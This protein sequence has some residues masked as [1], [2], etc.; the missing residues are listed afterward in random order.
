MKNVGSWCIKYCN[1]AKDGYSKTA[2]TDAVC[3]QQLKSK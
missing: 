1:S 2:S 3:I